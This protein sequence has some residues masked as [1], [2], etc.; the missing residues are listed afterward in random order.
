[1]SIGGVV[2]VVVQ[3]AKGGWQNRRDE[4][5]PDLRRLRRRYRVTQ[6]GVDILLQAGGIDDL[7]SARLPL[8]TVRPFPSHCLRGRAAITGDIAGIRGRVSPRSF[9]NHIYTPLRR[10]RYR[11]RGLLSDSAL[12]FAV[13]AGRR[14][15]GLSCRVAHRRSPGCSPHSSSSSS[16][17]FC[18]NIL[19]RASSSLSISLSLH[20]CSS[21]I[22][23]A[24]PGRRPI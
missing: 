20:S 21:R 23:S 15:S 11:D 8:F 12:L 24:G 4:N 6:G 19:L 17:S 16:S 22:R 13:P 10:L 5:G 9:E 1:M 18:A 14:T 3:V 2:V 7:T